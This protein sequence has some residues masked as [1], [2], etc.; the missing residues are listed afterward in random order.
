MSPS[1]HSDRLAAV[2]AGRARDFRDALSRA[3]PVQQQTLFHLLS[4]HAATAFGRAHDFASIRSVDDYRRR[5]PI[6][7]PES[8]A[9]WITRAARGEADVLFSGRG[10]AAELTGGSTSGRRLVV[11]SQASLDEFQQAALPWL[12]DLFTQDPSLVAQSSYWSI[13]PVGRRAAVPSGGDD[14]AIVLPLGLSDAAYLGDTAGAALVAS[15]AVPPRVAAIDDLSAWQRATLVH[16]VCCPALG[17]V[18]V[19]SPTFFLE[20]LRAA[21]EQPEALITACAEVDPGR[22][23]VLRAARRD[24]GFDFAAVWPT[25]RFVSCWADAA[26]AAPAARLAARLPQARLQSKGLLATEGAITIPMSPFADPVLA[27]RSG[28]YEFI[29]ETGAVVCADAVAP[30]RRY[31]VLLTNSSGLYRYHLGDRVECT[32]HALGAPMLRFVGRSG[33]V[34][35]LVGE[36]ID[37]AFVAGCIDALRDDPRRG[38]APRGDTLRGDMIGRDV[39]AML[40]PAAGDRPHY[41]L[42]LDTTGTP[43]APGR[44]AGVAG[45]LDALLSRNPQYA[46]ARSL[47]QL[48][49]VQADVMPGLVARWTAVRLAAGQS[50]GDIKLATLAGPGDLDRLRGTAPS[51]GAASPAAGPPTAPGSRFEFAIA[52]RDDDAGLRARLAADVMPGSIA[53]TFRR[54]PS[55]FDSAH[56][57]GTDTTVIKC[58]ERAT[59]RIVGMSCRSLRRV[60]IAGQPHAVAY[61]SDLR[62]DAAYRNGTLLARGFRH[63]AALHR[64]RPVGC[65]FA[66]IYDGNEPARRLLTSGR[67]GLPEFRP[68][69][70]LLTPALLLDL[71]R[72]VPRLAG[73]TFRRATAADR[74]AIVALLVL[75]WRAKTLSPAD[76][77]DALGHGELRTVATTDFFVAFRGPRLVACLAAWDQGRFRQ[78]HVEGYS[79]SIGRWRTTYN[80]LTRVTPFK[81]LPA[82][83]E[84]IPHLYLG[85]IASDGNDPALFDALLRHACNALRGGRW[86]HAIVGL[87]ES[88]PLS[89]VL[90]GHRRIQAAGLIHTVRFPDDPPVLFEAIDRAPVRYLEAGCL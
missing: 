88:D 61:L 31:E 8:L 20:L 51:A 22:A 3:M 7:T 50:I 62:G 42:L 40:A 34:G 28:F 29:D 78:T 5:V 16:L 46:Y 2:V 33:R 21:D 47:G 79:G 57:Q 66:V 13:S 80:L 67:A 19:W 41:R 75:E 55:Y 24:N 69:D 18:S 58:V 39:V 27:I 35:D 43:S 37:E 1:N 12:D 23:S 63:L 53:I 64:E 15:L 76:P 48:G 77:A 89:A 32:G 83:G 49:P 54:E 56:L 70:R 26:S 52:T 17:L 68:I 30:G 74:D 4:S 82:P 85:L 45:R 36:K 14:Q 60:T 25:L 87:C 38:E 10:I 73:V 6:Q 11:Y 84:R 71:P 59:G 9:P 65:S 72:R 90:A 86:H 81:P 44:P